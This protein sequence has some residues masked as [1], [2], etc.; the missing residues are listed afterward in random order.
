MGSRP[1]AKPEQTG[2]KPG[3]GWLMATH[4]KERERLREAMSKSLAASPKRQQEIAEMLKS[5]LGAEDRRP[6][7]SGKKK[8]LGGEVA[9]SSYAGA[10]NAQSEKKRGKK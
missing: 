8:G 10:E 5:R 2:K 9:E 6:E 3:G 1:N 4:K 7:Q